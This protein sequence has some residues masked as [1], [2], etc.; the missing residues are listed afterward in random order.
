MVAPRL[1]PTPSRSFSHCRTM[2]KLSIK[3]TRS[4][5]GKVKEG[6]FNLGAVSDVRGKIAHACDWDNATVDEPTGSIDRQEGH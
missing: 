4:T 1:P 6:K 5:D 3:T 2:R